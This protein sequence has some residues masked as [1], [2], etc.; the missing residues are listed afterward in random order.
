V[1]DV[2]LASTSAASAT[3]AGSTRGPQRVVFDV[4]PGTMQLRLSVEGA[5][6]G[7][8]DSGIRDGV[9]PGLTKKQTTQSTP[10]VYRAR[11]PRELQ[12]MKGDAQAVPA[13]L[14]EFSRTDRIFVRI[15]A[16]GA[17][18]PKL[19]AHLLNRTGQPMQ[20]MPVT[21]PTDAA[22]DS[23]IDLPVA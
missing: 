2:A 15:Q 9:V 21:A 19:E 10:G 4:P 8:I 7:V 22:G 20:E 3:S 11:T 6:A 5:T 18:G 17:G 14:R 12:Q 16:Y 13:T 23:I 1:P